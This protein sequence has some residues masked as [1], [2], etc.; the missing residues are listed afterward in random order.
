[1]SISRPHALTLL[2]SATLLSVLA[3]AAPSANTPSP[4]GASASPGTSASPTAP[5][6]S[7]TPTQPTDRGWQIFSGTVPCADKATMWWDNEQTAFWG[8]GKAGTNGLQTSRDGGM[9]WTAQVKF[10]GTKIQ[11]ITRAP[12]NTLYVSGILGEGPVA[13]VNESLPERLDFTEL[14]SSGNNAFTSVGQG[15]GVA[16]TADGQVLVDSLTGTNAVYHPGDNATGKS[17]FS[18]TCTGSDRSNFNP[19]SSKSW[20][21]LH[22]V[23]EETLANP[24][25][26]A[27]QITGVQALNN[28]FYAT[29]RKINEPAQVRLPSK[30]AGAAY[31]FQTVQLQKNSEDGELLDLVVWP[32]GR[33][34]TVGT[35]QTNGAY[36]PLIYLC[37]AGKDCYNASNWQDI[38]LDLHGFKY[39]KS[40]RDGRAVDASG[41]TVVVVGNFVPNTGG[42]AVIS[43]DGGKTWKD[44]TPELSALTQ[45]GKLDL[46][47]DVK[48]FPSG[49][50]LLFGEENFIYTP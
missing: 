15:E 49:K 21:E 14:Y 23:G 12:D 27:Y 25:A 13:T 40:A 11:G 34:M 48:V 30:L 4:P 10:G 31:H 38:E 42:W 28:R 41:D 17:W 37:D 39:D 5:G 50:I 6:S 2:T 22:G 24:D 29:G 47:Y 36:L 45:N 16:V 1:M 43:Q 9:T 3:C 46:L 8:C 20:C 35:D 33:L 32:N 26:T 18:S 44:L 7:A 19:D